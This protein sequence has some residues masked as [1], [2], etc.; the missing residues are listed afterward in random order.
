MKQLPGIFLAVF[1]L[2]FSL[3]AKAATGDTLNAVVN[4]VKVYDAPSTAAQ[5]IM[6]LD[7]GRKLKELRRE[8]PW[9]KVII[10]GELGKD[11]WVHSSNVAPL[12]AG[13]E[14]APEPDVSAGKPDQQPRKTAGPSFMLVVKGAP[15]R[16]RGRCRL[17]NHDGATKEIPIGGR[18]PKTYAMN[19]KAV[20]CRV[21]RVEQR[22]GTLRVELYAQG[23]SIP[24]GANQTSAAFG[25]VHV[26]S[27]GPWG[28][29]YG[30]RCSRVAIF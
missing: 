22:A 30:R 20:R 24:L 3:A 28:K 29:A 1:V 15:Q 11:G 21:D 26:R 5:L 18:V 10:Y 14:K 2:L 17:V 4:G 27:N 7:Q 16:F 23:R 9:I 13:T 19:G 8:G 12:S 25:C 6:T